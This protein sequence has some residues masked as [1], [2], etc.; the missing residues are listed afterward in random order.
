MPG[1][2]RQRLEQSKITIEGL[3]ETDHWTEPEEGP[4]NIDPEVDD[5]EE[6]KE[7]QAVLT[8]DQS[9]WEEREDDEQTVFTTHTESL[10]ALNSMQEWKVWFGEL[11]E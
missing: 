4:W 2:E 3:H 1:E 6:T 11:I 5:V 8:I 10:V 7:I 9:P